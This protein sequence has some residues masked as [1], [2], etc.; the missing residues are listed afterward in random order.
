MVYMVISLPKILQKYHIYTVCICSWPTLL[1]FS[2]ASAHACPPRQTNTSLQHKIIHQ[3]PQEKNAAGIFN[4]ATK[5]TSIIM[6]T[7]LTLCL[8]STPLHKHTHAPAHTNTL[9]LRHTHTHAQAHTQTHTH[10]HTHTHTHKNTSK[11]TH[12]R[13][14][15]HTFSRSDRHWANCLA[16]PSIVFWRATFWSFMRWMSAFKRPH[17]SCSVVCNQTHGCV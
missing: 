13:T 17:I 1:F 16:L 7:Q 3:A 15:T 5:I 2:P 11:H 9:T 6:G 12:T 10:A 4:L 14:H 8:L